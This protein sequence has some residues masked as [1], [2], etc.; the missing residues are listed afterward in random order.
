MQE[1]VETFGAAPFPSHFYAHHG[2]MS[3]LKLAA[4]PEYELELGGTIR[5]GDGTPIGGVRY[6]FRDEAD[7]FRLRVCDEI[8]RA[9][10]RFMVDIHRMNIASE[11]VVWFTDRFS[12]SVSTDS[13]LTDG[14]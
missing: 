14:V 7:G 13:V 11:F 1:T 12:H 9:F 4:H 2:D 5:L 6:Q 8:P 10:P 3:G